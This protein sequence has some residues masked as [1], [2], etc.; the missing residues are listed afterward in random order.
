MP[1]AKLVTVQW[2]RT[3]E[4]RVSTTHGFWIEPRTASI[5]VA[6]AAALL[7]TYPK[8]LRRMIE[9]GY[10]PAGR[11]NRDGIMTVRVD[12]CA[13]LRIAWCRKKPSA[14]TLLVTRYNKAAA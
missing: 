4:V 1:R 10:L 12:D 3:G 5:P 7:G 14:R 6:E 13:K 9:R 11:R 8:L 2:T